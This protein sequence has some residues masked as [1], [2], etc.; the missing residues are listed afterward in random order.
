MYYHLYLNVSV[1]QWL[2][3]IQCKLKSMLMFKINKKLEEKKKKNLMWKYVERNFI[4]QALF[5][6]Q[7]T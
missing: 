6:A 4:Q 3:F 1:Y 5:D 7:V 2:K